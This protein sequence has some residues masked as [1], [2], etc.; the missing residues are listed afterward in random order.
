MAYSEKGQLCTL[1]IVIEITSANVQMTSILLASLVGMLNK[2]LFRPLVKSV[3]QKNNFLI[4]QPKH[5]LWVLKR[6]VSMRLFFWAPKT[7]VK[8]YRYENI[9]NFTLTQFV[10]L[11][12]YLFEIVQEID[13]SIPA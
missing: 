5:M 12:L 4:S 11:N 6:T 1:N 7:Y 2:S 3:Y 13:Q 8:T 10:Y 9:Y